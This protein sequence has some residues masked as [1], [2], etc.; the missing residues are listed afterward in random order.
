MIGSIK[1]TAFGKNDIRGIY[2]DDVTED[3][4][5]YVGKAFVEYVS[6]N[7]EKNPE[8]IWLTVTRDARTHSKALSDSLIRGIVTSGANVVNLGLTPTPIGYYSE[9]TGIDEEV[10]KGNEIDGALIVTASHNPSEY[11]GLKMT[12]NKASLTESEIKKVKEITE[13]VMN[14]REL[15]GRHGY[16]KDFNIIPNYIDKMLNNFRNIGEG[17]KVVVDSANATGGVVAPKLYRELGCDVV[18]LFS[19]PDGTLAGGRPL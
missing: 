14:N 3:L 13:R 5:Y 11:N 15:G 17:I 8:D 16:N 10:T 1:L 18:E 9:F 12:F 19:E 4:Y 6:T 7:T 2:G